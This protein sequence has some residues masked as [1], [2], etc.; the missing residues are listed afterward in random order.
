MTAGFAG[1]FVLVL[2]AP[3]PCRRVRIIR[4]VFRILAL[5]GVIN[6]AIGAWYYLRVIAVMYLRNPIK[7]LAAM[8]VPGLGWP[9]CGFVPW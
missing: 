6:A 4:G 5:I 8:P 1:K 2:S 7:S 3:W 9:R